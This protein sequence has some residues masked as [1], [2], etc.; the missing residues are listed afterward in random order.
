MK[1]AREGRS[2]LQ[3][4]FQFPFLLRGS[5]VIWCPAWSSGRK[6]STWWPR[7][8][9]RCW[10][11]SLASTFQN[12]TP[13]P[14][15]DT[16]ALLWHLR[17]W[18]T[19]SSFLWGQGE[20]EMRTKG[21]QPQVS[22]LRL[23][24]KCPW[25]QKS[26]GDQDFKTVHYKGSFP[27]FLSLQEYML[28]MPYRCPTRRTGKTREKWTVRTRPAGRTTA[29]GLLHSWASGPCPACMYPKPSQHPHLLHKSTRASASRITRMAAL[30]SVIYFRILRGMYLEITKY[31]KK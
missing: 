30:E 24:R 20:G 5:S 21:K 29:P 11:S 12:T 19:P 26:H 15:C 13:A 8:G 3:S 7:P 2:A 23:G 1:R 14:V 16:A 17:F 28:R 22:D 4:S 25:E 31:F 27:H 18:T 9:C 6:P 10:P